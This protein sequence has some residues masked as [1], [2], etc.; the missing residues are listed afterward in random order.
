MPS[1]SKV[2]DVAIRSTLNH[3][4]LKLAVA[5]KQKVEDDA[6]LNI[7][8]KLWKNIRYTHVQKKNKVK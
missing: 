6:I 8:L 4:N 1:Q 5:E 2:E 7:F 3:Y